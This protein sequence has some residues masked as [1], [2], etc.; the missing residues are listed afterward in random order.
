[1]KRLVL[2][3]EGHGE[4]SALPCLALKLLR[5]SNAQQ[6][7]AVDPDVIRARNPLGLLKWSRDENR[8][9]PGLWLHYLRAAVRRP[10][11]GGVLALFDGDAQHFPA[12]STAP[13]CAAIAA[14]SMVQAA[15]HVGAGKTFSL[16]V[17]FACVE[18]ETWIIASVE[19]LA[20]KTF[21][22]GRPLLPAGTIFP[23]GH[24][25]SHGKRWLEKHLPGYRPAR[26]QRA[27]TELVDI[28][29]VRAKGLR[30][31]TRLGHAIEE[32]ANAVTAGTCIASP[33]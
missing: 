14:A 8:A 4:V 30:S 33:Q 25:E 16:A 31:F 26:D 6:H 27:L 3:G 23:G 20:G 12:G 29:L 21:P 24:P 10:Q 32:I 1:M 18:F 11:L 15:T 19:S 28:N 17:V 2:I 9:D 22:D 5:E 13:F 7:L